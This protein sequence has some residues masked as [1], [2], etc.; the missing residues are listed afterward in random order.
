M[1]IKEKGQ[2]AKYEFA[3]KRRQDKALKR[4][5]EQRRRWKEYTGKDPTGEVHHG[6]PEQFKEWFGDPERG[7]DVNS[8]EFYYDLPQSKHRL[9]DGSGIHTNNSPLGKDWN[10]VW[11]DYI[12]KNPNASKQ[13]V[14]DQLKYMEQTTGIGSYKAVKKGS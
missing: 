3:Q 2:I 12:T 7:L 4:T 1:T 13:Q 5:E 8:G 6:L 9:K 11:D 10:K 14:L